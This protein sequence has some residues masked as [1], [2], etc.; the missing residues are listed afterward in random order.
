MILALL[1]SI[2]ALASETAWIATIPTCEQIELEH[3]RDKIHGQE[4]ERLRRARVKHQSQTAD[5]SIQNALTKH[6]EA[7][8]AFQDLREMICREKRQLAVSFTEAADRAA[9]RA[10]SNGANNCDLFGVQGNLD[11]AAKQ[12]YTKY[13]A[14]IEE[15][16]KLWTKVME[17][18][19]Q[20]NLQ[21]IAAFERGQRQRAPEARELRD[22]AKKIWVKDPSVREGERVPTAFFMRL[23]AFLSRESAATTAMLGGLSTRGETL[24]QFRN[25]CG[26]MSL[27]VIPQ[28]PASTPNGPRSEVGRLAEQEALACR[29][30][31][32]FKGGGNICPPPKDITESVGKCYE[33]TNAALVNAR[34]VASGQ[35]QGS[36]AIQAHTLGQN[37]GLAGA[38]FT[39][40]MDRGYNA[41]NAPEGAVL[42]YSSD[43]ATAGH[44]HGHIEIKTGGRNCSDYCAFGPP[45]PESKYKLVGVYMPPPARAR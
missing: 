24:E 32:Q 35:L 43:P 29:E 8:K 38:G 4:L 30:R 16:K 37:G 13:A 34:V 22:E 18:S 26:A 20:G 44:R 10:T 15:K 36:S 14:H 41:Y 21:F 27:G 11:A 19:Y 17:Q 2:T 33:A 42:V 7:L 31:A 1:F 6:L 45:G 5:A 25:R 9:A 28:L 39:N 40:V 12:N 3:S 23:S